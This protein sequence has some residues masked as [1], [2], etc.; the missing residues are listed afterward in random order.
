MTTHT[1]S[2][3]LTSPAGPATRPPAPMGP[4]PWTLDRVRAVLSGT[5]D[6]AAVREVDRLGLSAPTYAAMQGALAADSLLQLL[7][8]PEGGSQGQQIIEL[9]MAIGEAQVRTEQRL[10]A[11][12][13]SLVSLVLRF[14]APIPRRRSTT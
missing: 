8:Q 12:E 14:G 1:P 10:S 7:D 4:R 3:P 11:I 6:S 13:A 9:L 5:M 2:P